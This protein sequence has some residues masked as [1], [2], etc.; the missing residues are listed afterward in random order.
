[1]VAENRDGAALQ[2]WKRDNPNLVKAKVALQ[3][4]H[5]KAEG[6][7]QEFGGY[8]IG[9]TDGTIAFGKSKTPKG[10]ESYIKRM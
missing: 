2:T 5:L 8:A 1:M 6:W 9:E 3:K 4:I 10:L 7:D